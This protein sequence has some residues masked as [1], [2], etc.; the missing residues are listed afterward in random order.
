MAD[1]T[2]RGRFVWHELL[3]PNRSGAHEFYERA[4]GWRP[5]A[6]E[7]D[8]SYSM[9]AGPRGPVGGAVED[10]A[11]TPQWVPYIA[12]TD[13]DAT[14]EAAQALG[15]RVQTAPADLPNAG[16]YAVLLDPQGALFGVH[17]SAGAAAPESLP[18]AGDF[19]WHELATNVAPD[20]AFAFYTELFGWDELSRFDMGAMGTYLIF[21]RNG[22]QLGGM[23][24]KGAAGRPGAAYWLGYVNVDDVDAATERA[25][26]ARASVLV[27][28]TDVPGGDRIAQLMDPHGAFFALHMRAAGTQSAPAEPRAARGTQSPARKARRAKAKRRAKPAAGRLKKKT[29]AKKARKKAGPARPRKAAKKARKAAVKGAKPRPRRRK[30]ATNK[31]KKRRR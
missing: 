25:K 28:P 11:G 30:T 29:A 4:V 7:H 2:V 21:G 10:R 26:D 22:T 14:A 24:N 13:V 6:W 16:R 31:K 8:E 27:G 17:A 20:E 19:S 9:F 3:T 15:A 1:P 5:Q 18:Q 23:F 12:T